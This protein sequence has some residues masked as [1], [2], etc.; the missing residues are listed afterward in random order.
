MPT[1]DLHTLV[2]ADGVMAYGTVVTPRDSA[3]FANTLTR[4]QADA[5]SVDPDP[6]T[7]AYFDRML[8]SLGA[9]AWTSLDLGAHEYTR[10]DGPVAPIVAMLE[11]L[12]SGLSRVMPMFTA[13]LPSDAVIAALR[14]PPPAV[15]RLLDAWWGGLHV[16][17]DA[18]SMLVGPL[19]SLL[20]APQ[21]LLGHVTLHLA[22]DSWRSLLVP[23][24]ANALA[25]RGRLA[26][27]ALD[28][29]RYAPIE[30]ELLASLTAAEKQRIC[31]AS[32]DL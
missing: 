11:L 30:H 10:G 13:P 25:I 17:A 2:R 31:D 4:A 22:A 3:A 23:V 8:T 6:T 26:W 12:R 27:L 20:G 7:P 14:D 16:V 1:S 5:R 29:S 24:D 28:W 9:L 19:F 18:R 32:L 15:A 21:T